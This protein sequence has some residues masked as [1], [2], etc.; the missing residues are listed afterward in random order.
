MQRRWC[1]LLAACPIASPPSSGESSANLIIDAGL[2]SLG[3]DNAALGERADELVAITTEQGFR[4]A[5]RAT[6]RSV[7]SSRRLARW[8][9]S[10]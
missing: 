8:I 9:R 6:A 3:G 2:L 5:I 1:H 10:D 7:S 4:S